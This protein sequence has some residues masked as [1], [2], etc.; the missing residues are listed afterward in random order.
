M[1][2]GAPAH[3]GASLGR[4]GSG[5]RGRTVEARVRCG[6]GGR[7]GRTRLATS[8]KDRWPAPRGSLFACCTRGR[9]SRRTTGHRRA[10]PIITAAVRTTPRRHY[11]S[12]EAS[13]VGSYEARSMSGEVFVDGIARRRTRTA[14]SGARTAGA[15]LRRLAGAVT[16]PHGLL[17]G[18]ATRRGHC[19]CMPP[20]S[21]HFSG[22][23]TTTRHSSSFRRDLAKAGGRRNEPDL[24]P[25]GFGGRVRGAVGAQA[26][27]DLPR[28]GLSVA[29]DLAGHL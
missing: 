25:W 21:S 19:P 3:G 27:Q 14:Q 10:G 18:T 28:A 7:E 29:T 17:F 5:P 8:T 22:A 13:S 16:V 9:A 6:P 15:W 23:S 24:L 20:C 11:S 2:E 1:A 12:S 4:D 26:R